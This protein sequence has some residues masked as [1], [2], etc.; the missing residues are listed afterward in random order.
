MTTDLTT[1]D[2]KVSLVEIFRACPSIGS[3]DMSKSGT[4]SQIIVTLYTAAGLV[5]VTFTYDVDTIKVTYS[6]GLKGTE[7]KVDEDY[8]LS[9]AS[10]LLT[11]EM[12]ECILGYDVEPYD[13]YINIVTD[14]RDLFSSTNVV[15]EYDMD[16]VTDKSVITN[17]DDLDPQNPI[18]ESKPMTDDEK[19]QTPSNPETKPATKKSSD[20][21][22]DMT[23]ADIENK[24]GT[25]TQDPESNPGA[26]ELIAERVQNGLG[27]YSIE[28]SNPSKIPYSQITIDNAA[29]AFPYLGWTGYT[30]DYI[31]ILPSD[32]KSDIEN[33][34]YCNY[35]GHEPASYFYNDYINDPQNME[36]PEHFYK[37]KAEYDKVVSDYLAE[38]QRLK[39]AQE[40]SERNKNDP[41]YRIGDDL[42][43]DDAHNIL[44]G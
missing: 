7:L 31:E 43:E 25:Y 42:S 29:E 13:T 19:A 12:I 10:I 35:M 44:W 3:L 37:S 41:N 8:S 15:D 30:P 38:Q 40:Q 2:G 1:Q 26:P 28:A 6:T 33:K 34:I 27:R 32:S 14:N 4:D 11:P 36:T 23:D 20:G 18:P 39:D 22:Y 24:D 21:K 16:K 5:D 9:D 17:T